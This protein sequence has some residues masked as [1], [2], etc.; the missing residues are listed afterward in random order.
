MTIR[1]PDIKTDRHSIH[2]DGQTDT[3]Y[4]QTDRHSIST[5]GQTDIPAKTTT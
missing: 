3:A 4:M 1:Q 2:T 5:D